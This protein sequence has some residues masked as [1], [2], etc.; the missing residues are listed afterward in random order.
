MILTNINED[1]EKIQSLI[2]DCGYYG[3]QINFTTFPPEGHEEIDNN[4]YITIHLEKYGFWKRLKY[5]IRYIFGYDTP[6]GHYSDMITSKQD[7]RN[8]VNNL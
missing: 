7:L 3:H 4:V 2:C 1:N 6:N 8:I 5:G